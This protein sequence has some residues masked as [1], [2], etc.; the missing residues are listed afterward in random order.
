MP[1]VDQ[2][3]RPVSDR[4][5]WVP[6]IGSV[7]T[8]DPQ[9]VHRVVVSRPYPAI[10]AVSSWSVSSTTPQAVQASTPAAST[11]VNRSSPGYS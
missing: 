10:D 6:K 8:D 3:G 9:R 5:E 1:R 4:V 7:V 11:G 2:P